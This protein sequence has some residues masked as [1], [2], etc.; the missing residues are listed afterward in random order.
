MKFVLL[1][2]KFLIY[3]MYLHYT[4]TKLT[5]TFDKVLVG[6]NQLVILWA[7]SNFPP[8]AHRQ[9]TYCQLYCDH[10]IYYINV[11]MLNGEATMIKL[12]ELRPGSICLIKHLALYN[13]ASIDP[14]IVTPTYTSY[15]SKCPMA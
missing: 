3:I 7:R 14:G 10:K 6:I 4:A 11:A 2:W 13:P 8:Y 1:T 9:T 15:S 5:T 12:H